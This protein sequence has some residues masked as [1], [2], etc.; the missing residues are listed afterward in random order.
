MR[1]PKSKKK[2]VS[3]KKTFFFHIS[4]GQTRHVTQYELLTPRQFGVV[5]KMRECFFFEKKTVLVNRM[6]WSFKGQTQT[7]NEL[8]FFRKKTIDK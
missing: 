1:Y 2:E 4:L 7:V 5:I 8:F 6:S 3:E